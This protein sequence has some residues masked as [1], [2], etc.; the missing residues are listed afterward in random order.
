MTLRIYTNKDTIDITT[1]ASI[2]MEDILSQ[3]EDGNLVLIETIYRTTFIINCLN[4]N[5]IEIIN[6]NIIPPI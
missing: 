2:K 3:M 4:I 1:S 5:A 6:T